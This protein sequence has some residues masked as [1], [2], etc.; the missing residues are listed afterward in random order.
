[1]INIFVPLKDGEAL[2]PEVMQGVL[3]QSIRCCIVPITSPG[4]TTYRETNRTKNLLRALHLNTSD[5]FIFMDSDVV[6]GNSMMV[7]E[8]LQD[9]LNM[10]KEI[11]SVTTRGECYP[12]V[13]HTPHAFMSMR[14]VMLLKFTD[15]IEKKSKE[16]VPIEN[17]RKENCFICQFLQGQE[18]KTMYLQNDK[19]SEVKRLDLTQK[20]CQLQPS[21]SL[22]TVDKTKPHKLSKSPK[23]KNH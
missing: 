7:E 13:H 15:Y 21:Q 14:G 2:M 18:D 20:D 23:P 6:I 11:I 8:M 17:D 10:D 4:D 19:N 5:R 22:L 3:N 12:K 16:E 1:M 9:K